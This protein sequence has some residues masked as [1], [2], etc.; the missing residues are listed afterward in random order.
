MS[1]IEQNTLNS[2]LQSLVCISLVYCAL[3][4]KLIHL[5]IL[6]DVATRSCTQ[7][8]K[9]LIYALGKDI[10]YASVRVIFFDVA[11]YA[12]GTCY[13]NTMNNQQAS[14]MKCEQGFVNVNNAH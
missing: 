7:S 4:F 1:E 5:L 11:S 12:C 14:I 8:V 3:C 9:C 6:S 10:F 13:V 2:C